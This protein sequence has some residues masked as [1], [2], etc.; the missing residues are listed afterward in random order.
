MEGRVAS[1]SCGRS[2]AAV[3]DREASDNNFMVGRPL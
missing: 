1:C 3:R 2:E